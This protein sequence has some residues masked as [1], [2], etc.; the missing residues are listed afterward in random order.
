MSLGASQTEIR[1]FTWSEGLVMLGI[2]LPL[3]ALIGTVVAW[4]LVR[5]LSGIFDPPPE[6]LSIPW[7]YLVLVLTGAIVSTVGAVFVQGVWSKEW[8]VRELRAGG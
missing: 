1:S 3:G 2:G 8:A 4:M 6:I 7:S 5:L